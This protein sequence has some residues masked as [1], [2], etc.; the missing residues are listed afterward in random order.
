MSSEMCI[1][2]SQLADYLADRRL[3]AAQAHSGLGEAAL[4]G[5]GEKSFELM[6]FHSSGQWS[7]FPG[8]II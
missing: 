8:H 1:R 7:V 5:D 2:D 6:K 4:L 3:G